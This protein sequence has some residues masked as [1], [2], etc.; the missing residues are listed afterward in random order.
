M[1]TVSEY[2][3][4]MAS[5]DQEL[6]QGPAVRRLRSH[7]TLRAFF[8]ATAAVAVAAAFW[9]GPPNQVVHWF[10][11]PCAAGFVAGLFGIPL[12][13]AFA[14]C[15]ITAVASDSYLIASMAQDRVGF[16][17]VFKMAIRDVLPA[18]CLVGVSWLTA[19]WWGLY[20]RYAWSNP[21]WPPVAPEEWPSLRAGPSALRA[22]MMVRCAYEPAGF[23]AVSILANLWVFMVS[24]WMFIVGFAARRL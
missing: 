18:T 22:R 9:T 2:N 21:V 12:L 11:T 14:V 10:I 24:Y 19:T 16:D 3:S 7:T 4:S 17:L 23:F 8:V 20:L 6:W 1:G 15:L 13:L 5:E